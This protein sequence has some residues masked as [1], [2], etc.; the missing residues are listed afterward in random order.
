MQPG[1]DTELAGAVAL[2]V[3]NFEYLADRHVAEGWPEPE[4]GPAYRPQ[5]YGTMTG[6]LI[7]MNCQRPIREHTVGEWH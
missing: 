3:Q 4:P 5:D 1:P 2:A 6:K 7:C